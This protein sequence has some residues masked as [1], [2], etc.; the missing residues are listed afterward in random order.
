MHVI[1][2]GGAC[3]RCLSGLRA[4]HGNRS[5][6]SEATVEELRDVAVGRALRDSALALGGQ[7]EE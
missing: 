6:D 1:A 5:E 3:I 4:R 7:W 2:A